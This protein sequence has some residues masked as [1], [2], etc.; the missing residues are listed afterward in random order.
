MV[1]KYH[2]GVLFYLLLLVMGVMIIPVLASCSKDSISSSG[3]NA[4]LQIV[5]LSPDIQPVN[6]LAKYVRVSTNTYTYPNASGYFLL[7]TVN[8]PFQIRNV[9]SATDLN[10]T[11]LV[12]IEDTIRPRVPYTLF[13]TGLKADSSLTSVLTVDTG[14]IPAIGRGKVRLVN[15][16]P[17]SSGLRITF[18]DT[19]A[20][21][22][23]AYKS[24]TDYIEVTAGSYN[25]NITAANA[26][27]TVLTSIPNYNILDGK[28]YTIYAYGLSNRADSARYGSGI[29]LNT[30]P[31]NTTY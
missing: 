14:A 1:N 10:P 12:T 22:N 19:V 4:R 9:Q 26:P 11:N 28:L 7:N 17:G 25:I 5:N 21:K 23:V 30:L 6:L 18:N 15:G 13:I 2:N 24:V 3:L 16:M 8:V 27:T 31:P 20:F 29:I